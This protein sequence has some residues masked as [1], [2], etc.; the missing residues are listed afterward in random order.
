MAGGGFGD[1]GSPGASGLREPAPGDGAAGDQAAAPG[2]GTTAP[3]GR[4]TA[5]GDGTSGTGAA[6][7]PSGTSVAAE[8]SLAVAAK[9]AAENFPVALRVLPRRYRRHLTALYGFA[10]LADDIGDEPLPGVEPGGTQ[11]GTAARLRVL[12]ALRDDVT[13]GYDGTGPRLP[14]IR[15]LAATARECGI[16]R[17]PFDDLIEANRQDQRVKRYQ[18]IDELIR[19]CELSANPVGLVVLHIF[20]AA[21]AERIRL[22]DNI[23]TALQIIEHCQDVREDLANGRIYLPREDMERFGCSEADLAEPAAAARVRE[24]IGFEARR[25]ARMLDGGAPLVGTLRGAARLAVAGYV[26]GGRAALAAIAAAGY[27]VLRDTPRPG[28]GR[29]VAGLVRSFVTGR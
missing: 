27:D 10:R 20:G 16:P 6:S 15:A 17:Q 28:K 11:A 26:A 21:T 7:A 22:S 2:D 14:A 25:A 19:Y 1:R 24:L 4:T 9:A 5:P 3:G 8:V 13:R 18:T 23:C 12:D 29:T